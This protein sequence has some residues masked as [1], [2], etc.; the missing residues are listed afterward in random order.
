MMNL[1]FKAYLFTLLSDFFTSRKILQHEADGFTSSL[2]E[3]VLW[4]FIAVKNSSL[5]RA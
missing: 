3:V 2:K 4:T 5:S 1:A